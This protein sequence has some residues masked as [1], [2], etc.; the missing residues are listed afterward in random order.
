MD[1]L[2]LPGR[3]LDLEGAV[4]IRD[5]GGYS[6]QDGHSTRWKTFLRSGTMHDLPPGSQSTLVDYGVRTIIDLRTTRELESHPN[7]FVHSARV[8]Y[9]HQNMIGDDPLESSFITE[10][11]GERADQTL[12]SYGTIIDRRQACI[13]EI[14]SLLAEDA[15]RPV[16]FHC[17]GGKDRTGITAALLLSLAGVSVQTIA[18]DYALSARYLI[19]VHLAEEHESQLAR[20][21]ATWQDYQRAFCPAEGM[22]KVLAYLEESYGGAE[23][24]LRTVGLTDKQVDS[25]RIALVPS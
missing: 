20:D 14:F 7:V 13:G 2:L 19:E 8:R 10:K 16:A 6:A 18:D 15:A 4:N 17:A 11:S 1:E 12:A 9:V 23:G 22:L 21:V 3:H 5:L 25:L 24:Y